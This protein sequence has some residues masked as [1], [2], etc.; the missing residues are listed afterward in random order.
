MADRLFRSKEKKE[1]FPTRFTLNRKLNKHCLM[2]K[3]VVCSFALLLAFGISSC[4]SSQDAYKAAYEKAQENSSPDSAPVTIGE[5]EKA[6]TPAVNDRPVTVRN[7]KINAVDGTSQLREF[8]VIIGSF[9]QKINA[10]SL[11]ERMVKEGYPA[12]LAQNADGMFRVVACS[13][14]TREEAVK[15]REQLKASFPDAWLL[16]NR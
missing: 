9:R 7:E 15:A 3:Y 6:E 13:F 4:K 11:C 1:A 2:K 14:D 8:N 5:P 12:I 16:I 10:T